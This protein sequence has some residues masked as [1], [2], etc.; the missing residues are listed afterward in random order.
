M[1]PG[2]DTD[3]VMIMG[4]GQIQ[5]RQDCSKWMVVP[6]RRAITV[7]VVALGL[8]MP[9]HA[10][11]ADLDAFKAE[12]DAFIG[13]LG[14]SSNGVVKWVGSDPYEMRRDGDRMVAVIRNVR[15]ALGISE[16]DR[17]T[18]DRIEIRRVGQKDDGKLIEFA[19]QL[20]N[21][22]TLKS[23]DDAE[24]RIALKDATAS[25]LIEAQT[26]RGRESALAVAGARLDQT[27]SGAWVTI[28]P[29]S[30]AS[31]LL[32]EPNG[33]WS[34]PVELEVQKIEYFLPQAPVGGSISRIAFSGK[35]AGPSLA[36]LDKLRDTLDGLQADNTRS[37][38][39]RGADFL[40]SLSSMT[41][42]FQAV[43]GHLAVEGVAVRSLAGHALLSLGKAGTAVAMTG[44]DGEAAAIRFNMHYEGLEFAPSVLEAAKVPHR[45][46]VDF[47]VGNISTEAIGKL[48][49]AATLASE[50]ESPDGKQ[51]SKQQTAEQMLGA[52]AMLNPTFRIYDAAIETREFGVDLTGEAK[53]SPLTPNG[54]SAAGDMVVRGFDNLSE[55]GPGGPLADYFPVLKEL[56]SERAAPDGTS[57]LTFHLASEPPKW[58]TINGSDVSGWFDG[59]ELQPSQPRQLKPADPPLQG[60]DVK[61]VQRALVA[62]KITVAEDGV[63]SP[64]T[65]AAVARFQK[66]KGIN[67]SGVVDSATRQRLG[68]AADLPRQGG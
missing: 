65:A 46:L 45:A 6:L 19:V 29:L 68:I 8:A 37:P 61:S 4:G 41:A 9:V 14:P 24:T 67:V 33:G 26:G 10:A 11:E 62:A 27:D 34:G 44:L 52:A 51:S 36:S 47:G 58:L 5:M 32:A 50:R 48:L 60:D 18:L 20:P 43:S 12:I 13:R 53:G 54:Y 23:A 38:E 59:S 66:Q 39:A 56:G 40:A 17:L 42:P 49:R 15:L 28:G 30:M 2:S 7:F 57:R 22:M 31:K 25:A 35:S 64:A 63:Y 55:L 16:V 3:T 21:Q 1:A